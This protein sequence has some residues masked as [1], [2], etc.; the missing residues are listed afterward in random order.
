MFYCFVKEELESLPQDDELCIQQRYAHF[1]GKS[2]LLSLCDN[3]IEM[4][5]DNC[6]EINEPVLVR[7]TCANA[8]KAISFLERS[9]VSL[10]ESLQDIARINCWYQLGLT[11]RPMIPLS[12]LDLLSSERLSCKL[13]DAFHGCERLFIKTLEKGSS[14]DIDL[15]QLL[16]NP[17]VLLYYFGSKGD[18]SA[19][20]LLA[21]PY[22]E[23][24]SDEFGG[25]EGR[26][27]VIDGEVANSSRCVRRL[28]SCCDDEMALFA[29]KVVAAIK[30]VSKPSFPKS[31]VLDV[32]KFM[33]GGDAFFDIVELNPLSMSLCYSGNS[34]FLGKAEGL[35]SEYAYDAQFFP[36]EYF[37]HL[38]EQKFQCLCVS[39]T[40]RSL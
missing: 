7:S 3:R 26:F 40:H 27:V 4:G 5:R 29:E 17:E 20:F 13:Q 19:P 25:V 35:G 39:N 8:T 32:G 37:T 36:G 11:S 10:V 28:A 15:N 6:A 34:V 38:P 30:S 18:E 24:C 31:Y 16:E 9:G 21:A 2:L 12:S 33:A 22:L 14:I 1:L 23:I